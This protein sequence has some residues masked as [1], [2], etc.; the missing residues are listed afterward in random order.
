MGFLALSRCSLNWK[1]NSRGISKIALVED[2]QGYMDA[3]V[4]EDNSEVNRLHLIDQKGNIRLF[5]INRSS[6]S[7]LTGAVFSPSGK[8][9]FVNVQ[10]N[11]ETVAITGPWDSVKS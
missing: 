9:L 10:V 2:R 7:E 1:E 11:G 5:A 8:T 4:C 3:L 6:A